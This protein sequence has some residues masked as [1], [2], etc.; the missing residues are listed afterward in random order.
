M[1]TTETGIYKT[2]YELSELAVYRRNE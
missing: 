2:T 1:K